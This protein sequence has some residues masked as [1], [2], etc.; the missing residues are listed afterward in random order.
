MSAKA[1]NV[2]YLL[3]GRDWKVTLDGE[4]V[5]PTQMTETYEVFFAEPV[6]RGALFMSVTGLPAIGSKHPSFLNL[7]AQGY[8]VK[9]GTGSEKNR[10]EIEVA[11]APVS[12]TGTPE[13]GSEEQPECYVEAIGWRTG[14]VA[15]DFVVDAETNVA[16]LNTAGQPFESVPQVD[17]PSPTWFKV[18]KTKQRQAGYVAYYGKVNDGQMTVGG[19]SCARDTLRCVQADEERVFNDPAGYQYRY[20]IALQ[21][22]SNEVKLEDANTATECGWQLAIVSTGTVQHTGLGL[23]RITLPDQS[24]SDVPVS[25]PVLLGQNGE[26]NPSRTDPYTVEFVAYPRTEFP[27]IFTSEPSIVPPDSE[28]EDTPTPG[29]DS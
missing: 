19:Y 6:A 28:D 9:E 24:G 18:F 1:Y 15:R 20:S 11:Y 2:A 26:F 13:D 7:Y 5:T 21:W 29:G 25:A 23:Q 16:V 22:L 17:R 8:S 27:A 3:P 12:S 4:N 14:S 10:Y